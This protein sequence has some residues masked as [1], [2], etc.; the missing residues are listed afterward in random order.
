MLERLVA[1]PE[2]LCSVTFLFCEFH[3][4]ANAAQRERLAAHGLASDA[5]ETLRV[6]VHAAMEGVPH[7]RLKLYWRSFWASCG[8]KQ[9]WEW[10]VAPQVTA[11]GENEI[12]GRE[13][14]REMNVPSARAR[15]VLPRGL[16]Q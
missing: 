16:L 12:G 2:L 13:A 10:R 1:A 15:A 8:D 11:A 4:T 14:Q 7:C 6:R 5:F 9:R 3:S